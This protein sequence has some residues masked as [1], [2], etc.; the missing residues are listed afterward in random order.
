[1]TNVSFVFVYVSR[2][3]QHSVTVPRVCLRLNLPAPAA[4]CWVAFGAARSA[5]H[6]VGRELGLLMGAARGVVAVASAS[7]IPRSA[8]QAVAH[9]AC[10]SR[11]R[12]HALQ[13]ARRS[14]PALPSLL[15]RYSPFALSPP[16]LC[17]SSTASGC[18]CV[19]CIFRQPTPPPSLR[20]PPAGFSLHLSLS[21]LPQISSSHRLGLAV[22]G[23]LVR[24]RPR[25]S[26]HAHL[27]VPRQVQGRV[28][29]AAAVQ[30]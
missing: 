26:L 22:C 5:N 2:G 15:R 19:D 17:F 27:K 9:P 12:G 1:V 28:R 11:K 25:R 6:A 30:D 18:P 7:S 4:P 8:K 13:L 29:V 20:S 14:G 21:F 3:G 16:H 24:Q 23:L 10:A